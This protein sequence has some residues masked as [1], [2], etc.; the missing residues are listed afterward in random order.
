MG[1]ARGTR[2]SCSDRQAVFTILEVVIKLLS[3]SSGST[4]IIHFRL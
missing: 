3:R 2:L 4:F 1:N